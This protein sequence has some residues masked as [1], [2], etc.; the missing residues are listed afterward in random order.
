[1]GS[2]RKPYWRTLGTPKTLVLYRTPKRWRFA[3]Y[4]EAPGG[5]ADGALDR[6]EPSCEPETAQAALHRRAEELTHRKLD[7]SWQPADQPDW[8]TAVVTQVGP[9]PEADR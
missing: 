7:V 4:F 3:V 6:P 1:M 9:L 8:W 2:R 5:T